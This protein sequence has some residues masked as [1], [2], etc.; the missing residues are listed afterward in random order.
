VVTVE[1]NLVDVIADIDFDQ[2]TIADLLANEGVSF[3]TI[4][5]LQINAVSDIPY[6]KFSVMNIVARRIFESGIYGRYN[7]KENKIDL[8]IGL[9]LEDDIDTNEVLLHELGHLIGNSRL[10]SNRY[11]LMQSAGEA[12]LLLAI[13][14]SASMTQGATGSFVAA[15]SAGIATFIPGRYALSSMDKPFDQKRL[16]SEKYAIEFADLHKNSFKGLVTVRS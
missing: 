13:M 14:N 7:P 4:Y 10:P 5:N 2:Q 8:N 6:P 15:I 1:R 9:S 11:M 3:D 12:A 16:L